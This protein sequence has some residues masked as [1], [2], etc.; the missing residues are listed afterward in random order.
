MHNNNII[1]C[2]FLFSVSQV[3]VQVNTFVFD[4]CVREL[5]S[6]QVNAFVYGKCVC[7]HLQGCSFKYFKKILEIVNLIYQK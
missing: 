7:E 5:L 2:K 1:L 4:K 6:V 3:Q